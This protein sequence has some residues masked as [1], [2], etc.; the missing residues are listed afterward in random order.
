MRTPFAFVLLVGFAFVVCSGCDKNAGNGNTANTGN[1]NTNSNVNFTPP[2][3][4]LTPAGFDPKFKA[5]N[6]YYPLVPGSRRKYTVSYSSGITAEA[7]AVV[8]N[9]EENGR[10]GFKE[11][12]Q[13][14]DSSG[15]YKI[16]QMVERHYVCDGEKVEIVYE[17]T[18]TDVEGQKT[19]TDFLCRDNSYIMLDPASLKLNTTWTYGFK[20]RMR[21]PGQ[22]PLEGDVPTIVNFTV[23]GTEEI[24]LPIGKVKAL[25]L[26]RK[27]GEAEINDYFAPGLGFVRRNAKEGNKWEL[28]EYNNLK[29][30]DMPSIPTK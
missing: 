21:V 5:C 15:G 23:L 24:D 2:K 4:L 20:T 3:P 28:K 22:A 8:D 30:I 14:I 17:K 11:L 25:L 29:S 10:K 27:V 26:Y 19:S 9:W 18:D 1:A 13:I 16:N 6:P 12:V 7:T